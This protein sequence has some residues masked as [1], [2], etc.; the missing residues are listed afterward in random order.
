MK[1]QNRTNFGQTANGAAVELLTLRD[2]PYACELITYGGAV[3]ALTVPDWN[4]N[5]V[6]VALG[7]DT[8][9]DYM[10]QDKYLGALVGRYA[11]RIG[12][13]RFTLNGTEYTLAA[14]RGKN[15]LHGG[16]VGFN[17]KVWTVE[18]LAEHTAT[19][20]LFSPDGEEGYPGNLTVHVT[21]T[22][23]GGALSI[24]YWAKSDAD[25][26]CNLTNHTYF[27][28][29]GHGSGSVEDQFIGLNASR[30][31]PIV[32]GSIPSGALVPVDG[33]PMDLRTLQPIGAHINDV[34]EQL[35]MAGGYD[36]NWVIDG[37]G[38]PGCRDTRPAAQ[39]WSPDTG[40]LMET[41]TTL[42][43]VQ[44]YA[45]NFLAGCP[46]GKGGAI[47]KDRQGFCL[48]TQYFPDSPNHPGFPSA[49]LRAGAEHHSKTVYR[50]GTA[51]SAA[52][53]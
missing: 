52:E 46:A 18:A 16:L 49:V 51:S 11:N 45:G 3:R 34:F 38:G 36:H 31:T 28:L 13:A 15:S 47:Y 14:N 32:P 5:P 12:G 2:G 41:L 37:W 1:G 19:L 24:E 6:D 39:A 10:V 22:L 9:E 33:T 35:T 42:P 25:T 26:I 20:S 29:S 23:S 30:Y 7:F 17:A 21:Y 48:E 4:G 43:G 50:F 40:I 44:F 8:L 27:N 53:L